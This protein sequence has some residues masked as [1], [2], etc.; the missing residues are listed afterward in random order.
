MALG[1]SIPSKLGSLIR[2][3]ELGDPLSDHWLRAL[4]KELQ[5]DPGDLRRCLRPWPG[6]HAVQTNLFHSDPD[7]TKAFSV[8]LK[9]RGLMRS[10]CNVALRHLRSALGCLKASC[11][12]LWPSPVRS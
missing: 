2:S 11:L 7:G 12:L 6:L 4:I 1:A 10:S 3:F 5:P 9:Q 8:P